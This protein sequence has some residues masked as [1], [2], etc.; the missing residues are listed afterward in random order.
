MENLGELASELKDCDYLPSDTWVYLYLVLLCSCIS[1][2]RSLHSTQL[3][4]N[5][6]NAKLE[7]CWLKRYQKRS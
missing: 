1:A 5:R 4:C 3:I 6:L 7:L 2:C